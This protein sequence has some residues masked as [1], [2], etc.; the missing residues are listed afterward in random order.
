MRSGD[1]AVAGKIGKEKDCPISGA[2]GGAPG[3]A[4]RR[5][6]FGWHYLPSAPHLGFKTARKAISKRIAGCV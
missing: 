1:A 5:P 6:R 3:R 2:Y 4:H